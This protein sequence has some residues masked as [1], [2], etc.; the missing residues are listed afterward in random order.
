MSKTANTA[1]HDLRYQLSQIQSWWHMNDVP[2][3]TPRNMLS[4]IAFASA[5][6]RSPGP[7]V[8]LLSQPPFLSQRL[9]SERRANL[10]NEFSHMCR[11]YYKT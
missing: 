4:S 2:L 8:L 10:D 3:L 1:Q 9:K 11:T 7:K 6:L 5:F